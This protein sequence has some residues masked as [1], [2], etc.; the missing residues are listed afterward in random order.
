MAHRLYEAGNSIDLVAKFLG[1]RS[2]ETTNRYYL[3][4][5]FDELLRRI[6]MPA[7]LR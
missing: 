7:P 2:V 4:L 6:K 1:H 5:S 3:R